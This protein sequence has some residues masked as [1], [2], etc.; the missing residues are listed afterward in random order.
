MFEQA[1]VDNS[2]SLSY[3]EFYT[4]FKN[5]SYGLNDNDIN[6]LIALADEDG[7]GHITWEEFVPI[8]IEAIKS[9]F[10]RNKAIQRLK[11]HEKDVSKEALK[12]VFWDE[13][14]K[15]G[16]ILEKEFV[17]KDLEK[18]GIITSF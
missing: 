16:E 14:K 7:D 18:T 6:T 12:E 2:G 8:G 5:L 11:T 17:K 1:D 9:F 3:D 10:A 15:S 13:I 4:A